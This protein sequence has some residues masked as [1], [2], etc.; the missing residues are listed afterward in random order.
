MCNYY[1]I[2]TRL[3]INIPM[4]IILKDKFT[5]TSHIIVLF[6]EDY[7]KQQIS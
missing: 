7:K 6:W 5:N 2:Y 3:Y 4:V 1:V